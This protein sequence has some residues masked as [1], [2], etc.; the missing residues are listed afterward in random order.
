MPDLDFFENSIAGYT[1]SNL[2]VGAPGTTFALH[3]EDMNLGSVNYLVSGAPKVWYCVPP[4]DCIAVVNLISK[5]FA[6]STLAKTC[7]QAVMHKR[8]LIHP[9]TLRENGIT[10]SRIVQ[11]QG[12]LIVTFPG[13]FHFGYNTGFN[14]AEATNFATHEWYSGGH[15]QDSWD[16]GKCTCKS[17]PRFFFEKEMVL[18]G[19]KRVAVRFGLD[20]ITMTPLSSTSFPVAGSALVIS[21]EGKKRVKKKKMMKMAKI[22]DLTK[23][24]M[25][26]GID[27]WSLHPPPLHHH[28]LLLL[29]LELPCPRK[30]RLKIVDGKLRQH[31]L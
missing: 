30:T 8:F 22:E 16:V 9:D 25:S 27:E 19:L 28:L 11:E 17:A 21:K 5:L 14:V 2:Y 29:L 1:T 26:V 10:C 6:N 23:N 15:L 13:A 31:N 18:K 3:E 24:D 4:A 20:P 7:P 12:D